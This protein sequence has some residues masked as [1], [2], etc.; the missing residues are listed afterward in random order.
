MP[1]STITVLI[2]QV[3]VISGQLGTQAQA[4]SQLNHD[5]TALVAQH[6][7]AAS[8]IEWLKR[9][10]FIIATASVGS[11]MMTLWQLITRNRK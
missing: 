2:E 11:F 9:F 8:D 1:D 4:I 7:A 5:Y 6:A 3:R 10:F